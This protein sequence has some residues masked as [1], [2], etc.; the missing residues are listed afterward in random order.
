VLEVADRAAVALKDTEAHPA[1]KVSLWKAMRDPEIR[2]G[3]GL[4]M[5]VLREMGQEGTHKD[6]AAVVASDAK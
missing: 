5:S 2:R 6:S 4:M 1:K 3:M